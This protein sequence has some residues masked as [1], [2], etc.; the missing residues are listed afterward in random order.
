MLQNIFEIV[1]GAANERSIAWACALALSDADGNGAFTLFDIF[2]FSVGVASLAVS[3]LALWLGLHF[4]S[5]ADRINEET[6]KTLIEIKSH[7]DV[8]TRF[9]MNELQHYGEAARVLIKQN[10]PRMRSK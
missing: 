6:Q 9:G 1:F 8:V 3:C 5:E 7:V 2:S 10:R 4:K